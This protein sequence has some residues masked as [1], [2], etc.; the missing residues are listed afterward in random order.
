MTGPN[1]HGC[2]AAALPLLVLL[3]LA[4]CATNPVS[5][6]H[7]FNLVSAAQEE[8]MGREGYQAV[9]AEY[10]AYE[11]STVQQY[12]ASVGKKLAKVTE[13]PGIDWH[14]TV[15]DDPSV[16][17]FAMPGGYVY[18]TRGILA[19]LNS[20][21]QLAGV[22][23]HEMG[24]ITAR[25]TARQITSEQVAG[26]GLLVGSIFV[27]SVGRYG[28]VAQQA[29]GLMFLGYSRAHE[30]EADELGIK[31]ATMA[32]YDPRVIPATYHMLKRVS[33]RTGARLPTFLETHPDP[34]DREA[35][36]RSLAEASAMGKGDLVVNG[37]GYLEM[38]SGLVYGNDPTQ[39]YFVN[40]QY[41]N[42][43]L[44]L[45]IILPPGWSYHDTRAALL[46][47]PSDGKG[48]IEIHGADA[49]QESPAAYIE[50]LRS[51]GRITEAAGNTETLSGHQAWVGR[52][53]ASGGGQGGGH[54]LVTLVRW[55]PELMIEML[56][57]GTD[58]TMIFTTMR[59]IKDL[60]DPKKLAMKPDTLFIERVKQPGV[61]S[62][63]VPTYGMQALSVEETAI[64]NNWIS[65][66][67]V[68]VGQPLKLVALG[69]TK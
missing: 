33:D 36:T 18:I 2:R 46:A 34:G 41:F 25:H 67:Q 48:G 28:D 49:K 54:M 62:A 24:H 19:Y 51:K 44:K 65:T 55:T 3:G 43:S 35:H 38:V 22:M 37:D 1:R 4:G 68:P 69:H 50:D 60:T 26:V 61:F 32:G 10:G 56:G 14:F 53:N 42:P 23:G 57:Q 59:S 7:E 21:A 31:Y 27:P 40:N 39:G 20:E 12:V 52:V 58:E 16:N 29:L 30:T 63:L 13:L 9:L 47:M 8:K 64:L 45:Q 15:I 17:A 6:H 5:G 11:D 66:E